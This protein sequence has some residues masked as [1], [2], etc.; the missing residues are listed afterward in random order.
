MRFSR[1]IV[2]SLLLV[3]TL[4]VSLGACSSDND[5]SSDGDTPDG[6][7]PDG[8][9][10]DGDDPDGDD[11]DGDDPDGDDPD[12]DDP[13]GDDP[14]GDDPDIHP[15]WQVGWQDFFPDE[16]ESAVYRSTP[17]GGE[18]EDLQTHLEYD[19][20]YEGGTWTRIVI[21]EPEPDHTGVAIYINETAPWVVEVKGVASYNKDGSGFTESFD[22]PITFRLDTAL[23]VETVYDGEI[24]M[25]GGDPM[26]VTYAVT[27]TDFNADV[28][29]PYG[30]LSGCMEVKIAV[31]GEFLGD[32]LVVTIYAHPEHRIV[33]WTDPPGFMSLELVEGWK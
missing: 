5:D 12:G 4:I 25:F 8:D 11:P 18:A 16:N 14:D 13:D 30:T 26:D 23:D 2:I 33:S 15:H 6:D 20:E 17:Y 7:D 22:T 32:D 28:T 19:V 31:S 1:M 21:G 9:D 27:V 29:V 24:S 10:P 3:L